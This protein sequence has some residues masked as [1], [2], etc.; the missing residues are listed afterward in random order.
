MNS[1]LTNCGI[2]Q[3]NYESLLVGWNSLPSLQSNVQFGASGRQYQ[4]GSASDIAR[5]NI[6]ASYSWTITGDIAVP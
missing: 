4:I 6:I 2:N 3:T 1:M 5:S